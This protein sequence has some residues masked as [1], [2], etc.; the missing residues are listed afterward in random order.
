M[1]LYPEMQTVVGCVQI[2]CHK[3][4][5]TQYSIEYYEA[6]G[7][8]I[9]IYLQKTHCESSHHGS[10]EMNLTSSHEDA[11]VIS[12]LNQWVKALELLWL[13]CRPAAAFDP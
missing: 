7:M 8:T 9:K 5:G 11:G 10:A 3:L 12:G 2:V 6:K 1:I 4:L 13:W